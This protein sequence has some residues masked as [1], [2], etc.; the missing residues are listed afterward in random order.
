MNVYVFSLTFGVLVGFLLNG[1]LE[2][3]SIKLLSSRLMF[4]AL[5]VL[6][7]IHLSTASLRASLLGV[8]E[9]LQWN[10]LWG[11]LT[12]IATIVVLHLIITIT[13]SNKHYLKY[14]GSTFAGGGRALI[15]VG[16][17]APLLSQYIQIKG[18]N[19]NENIS[20]LIDSF[21]MFDIGYWF[22]Y[23]LVIYKYVMPKTY[24]QSSI[25]EDTTFLNT[26]EFIQLGAV[27]LGIIF[28]VIPIQYLNS[29]PFITYL[30]DLRK[31]LSAVIVGISAIYLTLTIEWKFFGS[32]LSDFGIII[33]G[34]VLGFGLITLM[35]YFIYDE[36]P[37]Q[38]AL[39]LIIFL[40][41]PPSSFI[42]MMLETVGAP[43]KNRKMAVTLGASWTLLFGFIAIIILI[44][45]ALKV[46]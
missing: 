19:Q 13:K 17:I 33:L 30:P 23:C 46:L 10:L 25:A 29:L 27:L 38:I 43:E 31:I 26:R 20:F 9:T 16:V 5:T 22:F 21:V 4:F 7:P 45:T 28:M 35:I 11:I 39:P 32:A 24:T 34:R 12:C 14:Q 8:S 6:L 15:L 1:I 44:L 36:I 40:I 37:F 3:E 42:P 41:A 18:I 2:K